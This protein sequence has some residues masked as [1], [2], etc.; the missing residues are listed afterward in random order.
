M[1]CRALW[2]GHASRLGSRP[3]I[4]F[5]IEPTTGGAK[6]SVQTAKHEFG[7]D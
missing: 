4:E 3:G 6:P 7:T 2:L 5:H 1:I